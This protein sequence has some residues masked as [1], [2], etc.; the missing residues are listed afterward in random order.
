MAGILAQ[1]TKLND[2][3]SLLASFIEKA[4][5]NND[6][7]KMV[8]DSFITSR[9]LKKTSGSISRSPVIYYIFKRKIY[10]YFNL[11]IKCIF[12]TIS[13]LHTDIASYPKLSWFIKYVIYNKIITTIFEFTEQMGVEKDDSFY[14][15][16][17]QIL[18]CILDI[19]NVNL[20]NN[21]N[22]IDV[23]KR[24]NH[25]NSVGDY[26]YIQKTILVFFTQLQDF[27]NK[28]KKEK[29]DKRI[30]GESAVAA[31][32][33]KAEDE[34]DH[35][36]QFS[37]DE[38]IKR[39]EETALESL[40]REVDINEQYIA[41]NPNGLSYQR[42]D[43]I[44]AFYELP[45][46]NEQAAQRE[47]SERTNTIS[48]TYQQQ[49]ITILT[50]EDTEMEKILPFFTY[51]IERTNEGEKPPTSCLTS[52]DYDKIYTLVGENRYLITRDTPTSTAS[53]IR[54]K[55][56]DILVGEKQVVY[57]T[58]IINCN[59]NKDKNKC[60]IMGGRK[61]FKNRYN[62]KG[63]QRTKSKTV[64]KTKRHRKKTNRRLQKKQRK[65]HKRR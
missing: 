12:I 49:L 31:S 47:I 32:K 8:F 58:E 7:F 65:T 21:Q 62:A 53:F 15:F 63:K 51:K 17:T 45:I 5:N 14:I 34:E 46:A 11:L 9:G 28:Q 48:K 6:R 42:V 52:L 40:L 33:Q 23:I 37:N 16:I 3:N 29:E 22:L 56:I 10:K 24:D 18:D 43:E 64:R 55:L 54:T 59:N 2:I 26:Y 36:F 38:Y 4:D 25:Y 1:Q 41:D 30:E 35:F 50:R 19:C 13:L 61:T 39:G 60:S 27:I 57:G 20:I 44:L